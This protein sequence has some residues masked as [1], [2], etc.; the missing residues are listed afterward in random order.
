[1]IMLL[2]QTEPPPSGW[3]RGAEDVVRHAEARP[4]VL[5]PLLAAL[6]FLAII[7]G[8][9]W[10][11]VK[12]ALPAWR[13]EKKLDREHLTA[14]VVQRGKEAQE[15]IAAARALAAEQHRSIVERVGDRVDRVTG[16]IARLVERS[17]KHGDLLRSVASKV[18]VGVAVL[19]LA[20]LSIMQGALYLAQQSEPAVRCDP[21]CPVGQ[22]CTVSGCKEVKT[23]TAQASTP[24]SSLRFNFYANLAS[25]NCQDREY[26][27]P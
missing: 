21:P 17:E 19:I 2:A 10:L 16:E 8:G 14:L 15:D 3:E 20:A 5:F 7:V 1:M 18:G 25:D 13:E 24:H 4:D 23:T 22:R 26:A 6:G 12:H 27:C 9:G 11:F